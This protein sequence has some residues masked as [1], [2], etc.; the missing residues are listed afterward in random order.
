MNVIAAGESRERW[1]SLLAEVFMNIT[2]RK[3]LA[4]L[5]IGAFTG[6]CGCDYDEPRPR[7]HH[8]VVYEGGPVVEEGPVVYDY[9]YYDSGYYNGPYWYYH[10]RDG[11][12][13]HEMREE[14]ERRERER[15]MA[16]FRDTRPPMGVDRRSAGTIHGREGARYENN[17]DRDRR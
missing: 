13:Y 14:H 12:M 5:A 2:Y 6:L 7:V 4:G 15:H 1:S 9:T 3:L 10:D 8:E 16:N 17:H 11:H